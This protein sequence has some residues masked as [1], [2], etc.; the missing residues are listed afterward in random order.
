[1]STTARE[2]HQKGYEVIIAED[3]VADR[4]IPGVSGAEVTKTVMAELN[5]FFATVVQSKD[6]K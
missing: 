6:I 5:D 1:V 3:A 4:D 2:A